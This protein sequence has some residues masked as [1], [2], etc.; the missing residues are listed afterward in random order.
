MSL[1]DVPLMR[2]MAAKMSYLD[3]RQSVIAQNIANA[4]TPHYRSK[5]L[6]KVDFGSVL[7][8][9][10]KDNTVRMETTKPN[11]MPSPNDLRR[12]KNEKDRMTYEV[13]PAG[14]AVIMEEQMV[15]ANQTMMD[16]SMITNLMTKQSGM[17]RIAIGQQ[18]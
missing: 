14:N 2:A 12:T 5:D 8:H 11:H 17:Y 13:A 7:K 1:S 6:T 18:R 9:V 15:K 3:K 10:T 4:D 16:Y